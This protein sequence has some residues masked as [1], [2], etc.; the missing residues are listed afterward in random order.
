MSIFSDP[1]IVLLAA[2]GATILLAL[3]A[4]LQLM[5]AIG[6]LPISMAWGGRQAELTPALRIASLAAAVLLGFFIYVIRRRV[7]LIGDLPA[8]LIFRILSWV[9]TAFLGLNTLGNLASQSAGEKL[10]FGPIT[11]LSTVACLIVSASNLDA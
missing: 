4:V 1:S 8:P 6:V 3:A 7:G 11:L 10:V 2:N 5:L 9:I